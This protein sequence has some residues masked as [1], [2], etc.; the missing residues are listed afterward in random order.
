VDLLG[1]ALAFGPAIMEWAEEIGAIA[2]DEQGHGARC[3]HDAMA[4]ADDADIAA[5]VLLDFLLNLLA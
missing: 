1:V 2:D 4:T 5:R 3:G